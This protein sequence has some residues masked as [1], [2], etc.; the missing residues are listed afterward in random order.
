MKKSL[1]KVL[2]AV[3]LVAMTVVFFS[4][5]DSLDDVGDVTLE[6]ELV[7][8]WNAD[9]DEEATNAPYSDNKILDLSSNSVFSPYINK[10]KKVEVTK[11]TYHVENF[12]SEDGSAVIFSSGTAS[13]GPF[14]ASS[15]VA[16][17]IM[18]SAT[19][20]NLQTQTAETDLAIDAAGLNE[21]AKL[22][23][24]DHKVKMTTAGILSKTPVAFTVVSTF[25]V[26]VTA[27]ALE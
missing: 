22:L 27:N 6:Q 5:C 26:K 12:S 8:N 18:A 17:A 13:F 19:G 10:I 16:T 3:T 14:D 7:L 21:I 1:F 2:L 23:K 24:E 11:I 9:E 4:S 15:V 25:H 20:V